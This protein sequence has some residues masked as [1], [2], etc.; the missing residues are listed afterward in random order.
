MKKIV[1]FGFHSFTDEMTIYH[2][3]ETFN[4]PDIKILQIKKEDYLQPLGILAEM[5]PG[6]LLQEKKEQAYHGEEL[7]VRILLFA[8]FSQEELEQA[9]ENCKTC[10]IRREDLKAVLTPYNITWNVV[11]LCGELQKEHRQME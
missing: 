7:P 6:H 10:G 9:L 1:L 3:K 5:L 8:G 11:A 2:L 4:R